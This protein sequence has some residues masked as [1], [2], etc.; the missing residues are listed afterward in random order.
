MKT[1]M[2]SMEIYLYLSALCQQTPEMCWQKNKSSVCLIII[3]YLFFYIIYT[4]IYILCTENELFVTVNVGRQE[5]N[6]S[7]GVK[8]PGTTVIQFT[9]ASKS[10]YQAQ[11]LD[12]GDLDS[13]Q[14]SLMGFFCNLG[15]SP[16][17]YACFIF[18]SFK[19]KSITV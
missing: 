14:D 6:K 15:I 18:Q 3:R 10:L 17:L 4:F 8:K 16:I 19:H 7:T 12:S 2:Q 9:C 5:E 1:F 13:T 11:G